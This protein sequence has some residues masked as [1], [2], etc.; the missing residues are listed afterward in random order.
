MAL[1]LS[2]GI[3]AGRVANDPELKQTPNG[4]AVVT[5]SVAVNK[6]KGK[7]QGAVGEFFEVVAWEQLAERVA[8]YF[9]KGTPIYV[10]GELEQNKWTDN[11]TGNTRTRIILRAKDIRFVG[12]KAD[13]SPAAGSSAE[14]S[15]YSGSDEYDS[16]LPF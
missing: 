10:S 14:A 7:G 15:D 13:G 12:N 3:I 5:F 8:K 4:K 9:G 16:D 11:N 2:Q 6:W 1:F